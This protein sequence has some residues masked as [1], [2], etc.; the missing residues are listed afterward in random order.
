MTPVQIK[1]IQDMVEGLDLES[2]LDV[3]DGWD[4]I[5]EDFQEK[6]KQAIRD[7]HVS[8]ED[9]RGVSSGI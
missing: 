7:G 8:D 9:W 3:L 5:D 6:I 2:D 4:E 1:N